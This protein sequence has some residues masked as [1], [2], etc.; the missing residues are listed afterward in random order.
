MFFHEEF[1]AGGIAE[2][3]DTRQATPEKK[4][5][6]PKHRRTPPGN[7]LGLC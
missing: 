4:Q 7:R 1:T 3:S 6:A 2:A 5:A